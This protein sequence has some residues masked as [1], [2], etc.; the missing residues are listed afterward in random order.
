M[1]LLGSLLQRGLLR[2]FLAG[3][4]MALCLPAIAAEPDANTAKLAS[5]LQQS[6]FKGTNKIND[7]IWTI[8]FNGK[9]LPKFKLIVTTVDRAGGLITIIANPVSRAQLPQTTGAMLLLLKAND[10]VDLIKFGI[11]ND[12]DSFVRADMPVT[13]DPAFFKSMIDQV[14]LETDT[15]YGQMKPLLK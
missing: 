12:G 8:D 9:Q 10:R 4:A 5:L 13:A 11:D 6:A 7:R 2:F 1:I 3:I 14:A 15:I